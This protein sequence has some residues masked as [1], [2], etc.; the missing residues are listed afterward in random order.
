MFICVKLFEIC[1]DKE[2]REV[3]YTHTTANLLFQPLL[4]HSTFSVSV[5][6]CV[7]DPSTPDG[8]FIYIRNHCVKVPVGGLIRAQ[9]DECFY[10]I[11]SC[12]LFFQHTHAVDIRCL[13]ISHAKWPHQHLMEGSAY[14]CVIVRGVVVGK[15]V[16]ITYEG[17]Q[18]HNQEYIM[19]YV[20]MAT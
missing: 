16:S 10:T 8:Q 18:S 1:P 6:N 17:S 3:K 20:C 12:V 7:E 14:T 4:G 19:S 11:L 9:L 5:F 2:D 13:S 15:V